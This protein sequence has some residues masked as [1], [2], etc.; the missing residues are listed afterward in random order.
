MACGKPVVGF[1]ARM[2][3]DVIPPD[4][5]L[6]V[7]RATF[8]ATTAAL[9]DDPARIATMGAAARQHAVAT[10]GLDSSVAACQVLAGMLR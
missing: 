5:G 7:D 8:A 2:G 6:R 10:H 9:L 3:D 4:C 1:G